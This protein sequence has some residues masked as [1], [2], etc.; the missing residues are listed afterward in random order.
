[1][2]VKHNA[3]CPACGEAND[4]LSPATT[5]DLPEDGDLAVCWRC[6]EPAIITI[7]AGV[8]GMRTPTP[9][10]RA[11]IDEAPSYLTARRL[12]MARITGGPEATAAAARATFRYDTPKGS[13]TDG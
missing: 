11:E 7:T 9:A 1:M 12:V 6:A 4:A 8:L 10:E 5:M 3:A 2:I 13:P